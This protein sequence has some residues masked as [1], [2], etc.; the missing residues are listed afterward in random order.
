VS[1][2]L[3][4]WR[5]D[6][7]YI[8]LRKSTHWSIPHVMHLTADRKDLSHFAPLEDL[9]APWQAPFGFEGAVVDE[10]REHAAAMS[11]SGIVAGSALLLALSVAW[12]IRTKLRE[13]VAR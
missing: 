12:A 2:A 11:V 10:D 9:P 8:Q 7:G 13:W 3:D 6:G 1:Y 5:A 4:R